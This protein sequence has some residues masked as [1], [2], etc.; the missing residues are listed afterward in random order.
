MRTSTGQTRLDH[1]TKLLA[2]AALDELRRVAPRLPNR[3]ALL[4]ELSQRIREV[5]VCDLRDG[6]GSRGAGAGAAQELALSVYLTVA[7]QEPGVELRP[8]LLAALEASLTAALD[9]L[10]SADGRQPSQGGLR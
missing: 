10:G 3:P 4:G 2:R 7:A 9:S 8:Q 5:I 6:A 1:W